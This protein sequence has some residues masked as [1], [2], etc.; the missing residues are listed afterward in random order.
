MIA[1]ETLSAENRPVDGAFVFG[2]GED[3]PRRQSRFAVGAVWELVGCLVA[4]LSFTVLVF[5]LAGSHP[6]FGVFVC[7]V[8]S[9]L[10]LYT[11]TTRLLHGVFTAKDRL[12]TVCVWGGASI[13]LFP[14]IQI[15]WSVTV[16]G[17]PVVFVHFPAFLVHD[18]SGAA[19][20]APTWKGGMGNAII[21]T[22]EQV[23]L[24]TLY[25]V[26]ISMLTAIYL[27]ESSSTFSRL[28]RTIVNSMMGTPSIIAGLF[29]YFLW[30]QPRGTAGFSGVA[31]SIALAILMLPIM[32]RTAEEVIRVVPGALREAALAL[33]S[34]RW[35]VSLKV[36][37][38]TIRSGLI[39]AV[40]LG[41]ALAVGE[42]APILLTSRWNRQFNL[43][44][45]HG[46]QASLALQ[47]FSL[48]RLSQ[49]VY[50]RDAWGGAFILVW[51]VLILFIAARI[52]GSAPPGG[53]RIRRPRQT[54]KEVPVQ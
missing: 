7:W 53:R 41:V 42:T 16:R 52:I 12:A 34:P 46:P 31:A 20:N 22:A 26:P 5:A 45:F 1:P 49:N 28:V 32:I 15:I 37:L 24:A 36:V 38:P 27:S 8:L 11:V 18:M 2:Q 54:T 25:T 39:T 3:R 21:G 9:F 6:E 48:I 51:M 33:G 47:V 17:G 40:I 29:V 10:V 19:A 43:N 4:S 14:L 30:V 13:A 50:V 44:P 35:R 23:G